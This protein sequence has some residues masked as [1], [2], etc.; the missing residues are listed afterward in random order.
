MYIFRLSKCDKLLSDLDNTLSRLDN[1]L[2]RLDNMVIHA[3]KQ[4]E[5]Q[6][7]AKGKQRKRYVKHIHFV[8]SAY[9]FKQ[10]AM[11]FLPFNRV[12]FRNR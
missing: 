11:G 3:Q 10:L 6:R 7:N 1:T 2:S 12:C 8:F 9:A 4:H 5:V